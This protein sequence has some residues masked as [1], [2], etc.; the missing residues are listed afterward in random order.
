MSDEILARAVHTWWT[1]HHLRAAVAA[2]Y[3]GHGCGY[4]Q[5]P[6]SH[7]DL[8]ADAV[9][10]DVDVHGGLTYGPDEHGWVGFDTGHA[11]DVWPDDEVNALIELTPEPYRAEVFSS[12][13][14][15]RALLARVGPVPDAWRQDWTVE[16]L[17]AEVERLAAQLH[18]RA[19]A[20]PGRRG[21]RP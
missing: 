10:I 2:G 14:H 3:S 4:V 19:L 7:P 15:M 20:S 6:E 17:V 18:E 12:T 1:A 8:G 13:M 21:Y 16:R 5:L 9:D 11:G